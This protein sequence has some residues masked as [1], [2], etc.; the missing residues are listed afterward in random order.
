MAAAAGTA[1]WPRWCR[2]SP[3]GGIPLWGGGVG[4]S[5]GQ[6]QRLALT[7]ALVASTPLVVL[8][9]PTAH[10][11]PGTEARVHATIRRLR[12]RGRAVVLVAH[13]PALWALADDVVPVR[14]VA[15]RPVSGP[16]DPGSAGGRPVSPPPDGPVWSGPSP[17]SAG[18]I[19]GPAG[20]RGG[21]LAVGCAI[22]LMAVSAGLIARAAN[23]RRSPYSPWRWWRPAPSVSAGGP[24]VSGASRLPRL[25]LRG[26][27]DLRERSTVG[28]R[29]RTRRGRRAAGGDLLARV[30]ADVDELADVVVRSVLPGCVAAATGA[31]TVA[32]LAVALPEAG[33]VLGAG[34]LVA[35]I[36]AP[37][38]AASG[39]VR[40][41]RG[42][43]R[44]R[45]QITVETLALLDGMAEL[46]VAGAVPARLAHLDR[47]HADL[48]RHLEA[49]ARPSALGA[50]LGTLATGAA[51][52]GCLVQGSLAVAAGRLPEAMLAVVA[53]TPV[54]AAEVVLPLPAAAVGLVRSRA[55]ARRVLE[56]L[57]VD[58]APGRTVG[59]D[60]DPG[61]TAGDGPENTR[62]TVPRPPR[63]RA[64]D[65]SCGWP[66]SASVVTGLHLDLPPGR[67]GRDR[68]TE[69]LRE[70]H[71]L[72]TL[73][74]SC[75]REVAGSPSVD[76]CGR[77]PAVGS[78]DGDEAAVRDPGEMVWPGTTTGSRPAETVE[79]EVAA[80]P[81]TELARVVHLTA[82]D[83][84]IFGTTLRENLRV[85]GPDADDAALLRV[86]A[87][88]GL[89]SWYAALPAG[90]DTRLGS[91]GADVSGGEA[92]APPPGQGVVGRRRRPVAG[93]THRAPGRRCRR[94]PAPRP[95]ARGVRPVGGRSRSHGGRGDP[96]G[97]WRVRGRR[98]PRRR[99]G[100]GHLTRLPRPPVGLFLRVP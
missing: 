64:L 34:L 60:Q 49:A 83:A 93:R 45:A 77:S 14:A 73:P 29:V 90:L 43:A 12:D 65:L 100:Y 4:L 20:D 10:L 62:L 8:D 1:G 16:R 2:V 67:R 35:G 48:A 63:M 59:S 85:A 71:L 44:V 51:T 6:R 50:G 96:P 15:D 36:L 41:E 89:A 18:P 68:R 24:P 9:E 52:L 56:L 11:D 58:G 99:S 57:D 17:N 81:E 61:G 95:G 53:L 3:R 76:R 40:A 98:D 13:R 70:N 38:L 39:A 69:R 91:G 25:A 28:W 74:G 5:A 32:L 30:G 87:Q 46:T 78:R 22:G 54:A 86:L 31:V 88:A 19:P 97:E 72:L 47:L 26:V 33:L 23:N 37:A 92:P 42:A 80:V 21:S 66:G 79:V 82:E 75:R 55:A 27:V 84:H 94:R 7:R